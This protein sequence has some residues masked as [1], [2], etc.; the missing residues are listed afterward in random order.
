LVEIHGFIGNLT[1]LPMMDLAIGAPKSWETM[2]YQTL[3]TP[4]NSSRV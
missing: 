2:T 1:L 4:A 3:A